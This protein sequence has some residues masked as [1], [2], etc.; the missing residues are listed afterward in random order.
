MG[1]VGYM[2]PEQIRGHDVDHRSD[3]FA[4]GVVLYELLTGHHPF[5][6]PTAAD[7]MSAVLSA[8]VLPVSAT[9]QALSP[10]LDRIVARCLEKAPDDRFQSTRDLAFALETALDRGSA[11]PTHAM[12]H[13][14]P[15]RKSRRPALVAIGLAIGV[16][17]FLAWMG[18]RERA[19]TSAT[20]TATATA[21]WV[22][23][24]LDHTDS[25][26]TVGG[27]ALAIAPDSSAIAYVGT[28]GQLYLKRLTVNA[29]GER[30]HGSQGAASPAFSPDGRW[31]GFGTPGGIKRVPVD[32][33]TP[34][35][36]CD[37]SLVAVRGMHWPAEG[38]PVFATNQGLFEV[39]PDGGACRLVRGPDE[40]SGQYRF[41][42]PY[43]LP[44]G[45]G[46]LVG[47]SGVSAD[48]DGAQLVVFDAAGSEP[49]VVVRGARRGIYLPSGH[50][51]FARGRAIHAARFD[52]DALTLGEAR[53]VI[54]ENVGLS[55]V[56][57]PQFDGNARG[58][59]VLWPSE[60]TGARRRMAWAT[61]RGERADVGA[62][63]ASFGYDPGLSPDG[64][65]IAVS[66][67][68]AD[69]LLWTYSRTR[70]AL[71]AVAKLWDSHSPVWSPDGARLAFASNAG[72]QFRIS[73]ATIDST[74][75][76]VI[77]R[78]GGGFRRLS[79]YS[80]TPDG[81]SLIY[82]EQS[83]LRPRTSPSWT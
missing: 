55:T 34:D 63:P 42:S 36:M 9:G 44:R 4:V 62:S 22:S 47:I 59:I 64:D 2:P 51:L 26:A 75:E 67:G 41:L 13:A 72:E 39:P 45:R 7:T 52:L 58:D 49:H 80:W 10:A 14:G 12:E 25:L 29:P 68:E 46:I 81:R 8:E 73:V 23:I 30:V 53:P 18:T 66:I 21:R 78:E 6:R 77:V 1:T 57:L 16:L 3:V 15:T 82:V 74:Q 71:T 24:L 17:S 32:G 48:V 37:M 27:V 83:T 35:S 54:A 50:L 65:R 79:P 76:P 38:A 61:R 43:R 33:G 60:Q 19:R 56:G 69:H 31:L 40:T 70:Q 20:A 28:D 5:A 11:M